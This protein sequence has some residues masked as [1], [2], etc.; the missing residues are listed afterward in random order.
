VALALAAALDDWAAIRRGLRGSLAGAA[1]LGAVSCVADPDPWRNELRATLDR[2]DK[3]ARLAA[4]QAL[5]KTAK[6]DELGPVSLQLLGNGLKDA[7]DSELAETF[8]RS[9]QQYYPGD[10]WINY[11]LGTVL[12]RLSRNE[13]AIRFYTAARAIRPEVAHQLAHSLD[14]LARTDEAIAVFRNLQRLRPGNARHLTCLGWTL[15]YDG[16]EREANEVMDAALAAARERVKLKP[17]DSYAH[18]TLGS[19]LQYQWKYA[20]AIAAFRTAVSLKPESAAYHFNLGRTLGVI[21]KF[22]EAAAELRTAILLEP[23]DFSTH[24][25]LG[26]IL[27]SQG[28]PDHAIAAFRTA[29]RV[30]PDDAD[31]YCQLGL[32]L[33]RQRD[34]AGALETLRK[35]HEL[36]SRTPGWNCPSQKWVNDAERM[37]TLSHRV[38]GMLRGEDS[39]RDNAERLTFA[40]ICID[41]RLYATAAR[42]YSDAFQADPKLGDDRDEEHR[43]FA[44]YYALRAAAGRGKDDPPPD[45]HARARLR[46]QAHEWLRAELTAWG[47][48]LDRGD[49]K[50]RKN[51]V[52]SVRGWKNLVYFAEV[53]D[54]DEIEDLPEAERAIWRSFWADVEV[55]LNRARQPASASG[56][57]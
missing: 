54:P 24:Y 17:E 53:R 2:S 14:R 41:S 25:Y 20:E 35:G 49:A 3:P 31:A 56:T 47:Q 45:E 9:A 29:M 44:A 18:S 26:R 40:M 27:Q 6:I 15:R 48:V 12:E 32:L 42:Q 46:A 51:A 36:G 5:A 38:P 52:N 8:L 37:L 39:P 13:E 30:K 50:A 10:V 55:L 23:D 11:A 57:P 1:A 19:A 16:R 22:E 43:F 21:Q 4:L 34:F 7:G 28:K 33:R